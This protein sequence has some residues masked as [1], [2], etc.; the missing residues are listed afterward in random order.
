V[1]RFLRGKIR[2]DGW[3]GGLSAGCLRGM[4]SVLVVSLMGWEVGKDTT[5]YRGGLS[6]CPGS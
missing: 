1:G 4:V 5:F 6:E 2:G 3:K